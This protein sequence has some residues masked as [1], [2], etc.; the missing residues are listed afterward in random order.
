MWQMVSLTTAVG[1]QHARFGII[2]KWGWA[3]AVVMSSLMVLAP[4]VA[5]AKGD[6]TRELSGSA[7][8]ALSAFN[9][10]ARDQSV[11]E[12]LW[13]EFQAVV[14]RYGAC[15]DGSVAEM[16]AETTVDMLRYRWAEAQTFA[17]LQNEG[18]FRRFVIR[19]VGATSTLEDL[20]SVRQNAAHRC[21]SHS[22]SFCR[23]VVRVCKEAQ[24]ELDK[25]FDKS[26]DR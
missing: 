8:R 19:H 5:Y 3:M 12:N 11:R 23:E 25:L 22:A 20:R 13:P 7:P 26:G 24:L 21:G 18:P 14:M 9:N 2:V 15:D 6:C 4:R 16:F 17:P 10:R 1:R